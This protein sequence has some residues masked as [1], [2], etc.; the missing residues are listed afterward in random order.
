[1]EPVTYW[2]KNLET[3]PREQLE[4]LQLHRFKDRM[5]HVYERSP[6]YRRKF[7]EAGVKPHDIRTLADIQHVPFTI[8][9][10]LRESQ[11]AVPPW[12]DFI[13]IPPEEGVRVFQD[14]RNYRH[15]R[16]SNLEPS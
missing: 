1:M 2:R 5:R 3:M 11:A 12:G 9:E 14:I 10:E 15:S 4:E 6:M 8:K 7:D 13:C 16:Q